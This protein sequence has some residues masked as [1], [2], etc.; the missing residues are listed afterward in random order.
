MMDFNFGQKT[1]PKSL[2]FNCRTCAGKLAAPIVYNYLGLIY[3][4]GSAG[5]FGESDEGASGSDVTANATAAVFDDE[6][7]RRLIGSGDI[8]N[9]ATAFSEVRNDTSRKNLTS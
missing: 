1:T 2:S 5:G 9:S 7:R 3:E 8:S 6:M 4:S